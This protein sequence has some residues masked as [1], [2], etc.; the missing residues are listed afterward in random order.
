MENLTNAPQIIIIKTLIL[1]NSQVYVFANKVADFLGKSFKF[2]VIITIV[3]MV[4]AVSRDQN[5]TMPAK[6]VDVFVIVQG[7]VT[8]YNQVKVNSVLNFH[9]TRR[10][11]QT[12]TEQAR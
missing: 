9:E 6:N 10:I 3:E 8:K 4:E 2:L 7:N 12:S 5:T 11:F 1:K